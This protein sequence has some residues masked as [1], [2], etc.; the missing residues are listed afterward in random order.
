[1]QSEFN[2]KT[3]RGKAATKKRQGLK[4]GEWEAEEWGKSH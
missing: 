3:Q 1:M 2:A 4:A